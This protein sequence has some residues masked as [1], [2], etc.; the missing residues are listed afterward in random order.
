MLEMP[1]C[2]NVRQD[3]DVVSVRRSTFCVRAGLR[4][5]PRLIPGVQGLHAS[6]SF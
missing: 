4:L 3:V 6:F 1:Q 2:S 5:T